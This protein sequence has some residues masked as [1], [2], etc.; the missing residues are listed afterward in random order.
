MLYII[1]VVFILVGVVVFS[2]LGV[3]ID[4]AGDALIARMDA[5]RSCPN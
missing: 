4:H 1:A 5:R 3:F 2:A